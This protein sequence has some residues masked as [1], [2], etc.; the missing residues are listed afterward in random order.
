MATCQNRL[1]DLIVRRTPHAT[2]VPYLLLHPVS[3]PVPYP[4]V[5]CDKSVACG[6]PLQSGTRPHVWGFESLALKSRTLEHSSGRLLPGGRDDSGPARAGGAAP[7][8]P[9]DR[10]NSRPRLGRG[11]APSRGRAVTRRPDAARHSNGVGDSRSDGTS[12]KFG[13]S[14]LIAVV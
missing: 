6:R 1:R 2:D 11:A 8:Q 12:W 4:L 9:R 5:G 7:R 10:P 3:H 13:G 14:R